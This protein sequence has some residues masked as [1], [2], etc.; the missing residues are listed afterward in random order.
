MKK[1]LLVLGAALLALPMGVG[2]AD[3]QPGS[4]GSVA[5]ASDSH[6]TGNACPDASPDVDGDGVPD[7]GNAGHQSNNGH[8]GDNGNNGNNGQN[9]DNGHNGQNGD[10]GNNGQNGDDH[11]NACDADGD[12]AQANEHNPNCP[13]TGECTDGTVSDGNGGCVPAPAECGAGE[14]SDGNGGCVPDTGGEPTAADVCTAAN[15][16][17]GL[18]TDDTLGQT[19]YDS[20]LNVSPLFEDPDA[21]GPLSGA[22]YDGGTDTPLEPVTDEVGCAVDL[23]IDQS[24]GADL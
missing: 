5:R 2:I 14:V 10:D 19:L 11:G 1:I 20:G 24:T 18:L 15:N 13:G 23:L 6:D 16:D 8:N 9:G 21:D 7:C 3:A 22:I 4:S 12:H 17:P